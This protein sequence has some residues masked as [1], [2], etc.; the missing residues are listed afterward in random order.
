MSERLSCALRYH[1]GS[2]GPRVVGIMTLGERPRRSFRRPEALYWLTLVVTL[3]VIVVGAIVTD[4]R[5]AIP[6]A[7]ALVMASI[8]A[9]SVRNLRGRRAAR[10]ETDTSFSGR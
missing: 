4:R 3:A 7:I 10:A 5:E 2:A 8:L 9:Q 6:V 1:P